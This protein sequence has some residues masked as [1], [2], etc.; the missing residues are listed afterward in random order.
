MATKDKEPARET[1]RESKMPP[2]LRKAM[3]RKD[4]K[5]GRG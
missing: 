2:A 3:E 1:K 4:T 5:K